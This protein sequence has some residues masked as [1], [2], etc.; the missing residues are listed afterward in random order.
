MPRT[1]E[2]NAKMVRIYEE[3]LRETGQV[4]AELHAVHKWAETKRK[5]EWEPPTSARSRRF[6]EDMTRALKEVTIT[7]DDGSEIRAKFSVVTEVN[8]ELFTEWGDIRTWS[9]EKLEKS[10]QGQRLDLVNYA[11]R[12]KR[13]VDYYN[14]T[15]AKD[16]PFQ[17]CLNLEYD[18]E[19]R[20]VEEK[21]RQ[22]SANGRK[23]PSGQSRASGQKSASV[24][25]PSLP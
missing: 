12:L 15:R 20:E 10:F 5:W 25:V 11:Y 7:D 2:Y 24:P 6:I 18:V 13:S 16:N 23:R 4:A 19:L 14:R 17:L 1:S 9:K 3:Y 22:D 21:I 8:G